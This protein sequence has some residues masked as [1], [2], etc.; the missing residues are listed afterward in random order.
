MTERTRIAILGGGY[1]GVEAAKKLY[2]HFKRNKNVEVF[3]IDR[4]PYHT[5]MTELHEIAGSRTE[6]D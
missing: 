3:L 1:G 5:L 4:S 2:K 6:P